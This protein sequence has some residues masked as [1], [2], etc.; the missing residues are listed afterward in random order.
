ML[1]LGHFTFLYYGGQNWVV[2]FN[3]L[4]FLVPEYSQYLAELLNLNK[5]FTITTRSLS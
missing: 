3:F 2:F 5:L 4:A 1:F